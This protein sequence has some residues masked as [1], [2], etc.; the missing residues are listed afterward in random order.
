MAW[1]YLS[2]SRHFYYSSKKCG[3]QD[4]LN[5]FTLLWSAEAGGER[6]LA[7]PGLSARR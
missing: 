2:P 6:A 5:D 7:A 3:S 4:L 1:H